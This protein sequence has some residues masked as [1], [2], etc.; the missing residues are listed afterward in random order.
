MPFPQL[1]PLFLR[2]APGGSGILALVGLLALAIDT[3]FLAPTQAQVARRFLRE[4]VQGQYAPAYARLAP[5]VRAT[6]RPTAF[7]AAAQLLQQLGQQ[8]GQEIELYKLGTRLS[9]RGKPGQWF[10]SFSFAK[11][12]LLK[13]PPVLLEVTFRDTTTRQVLGFRIRNR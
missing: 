12:S 6:L 1:S 8:R 4:V 10:Y 2:G 5:E 9:G 13:P 11:D 7:A 3:Q